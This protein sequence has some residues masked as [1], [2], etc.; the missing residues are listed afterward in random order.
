MNSPAGIRTNSSFTPLPNSTVSPFGK[1]SGFDQSGTLSMDQVGWLLSCLGW[2]LS[3][4][5]GLRHPGMATIGQ[6]K[7][8]QQEA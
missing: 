3:C 4:S 2:L 6:K 8:P 7:L 5:G 1:L